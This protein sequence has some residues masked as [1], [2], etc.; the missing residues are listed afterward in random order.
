MRRY[1]QGTAVGIQRS[2]SEID[3]LLR[4]W[5]A[6]GA[7]WTD[8]FIGPVSHSLRFRWKY[9]GV[10]LTA[11]FTMTMNRERLEKEAYD[12]RTKKFSQVKLDKAVAVWSRVSH[13]TLVLMLKA[14]FNAVDLGIIQMESV[15]MP[16]LEDRHGNVLGEIVV[17]NL[18]RLP[19]MNVRGL[20]ESGEN[21][22]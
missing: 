19:N 12:G 9:K 10:T 18:V 5:G 6:E 16:F 7:Q 21:D 4:N 14:I 15:F 13:R 17:D 3:K 8:E 22:E 2:R 1:A 20:L 11:K